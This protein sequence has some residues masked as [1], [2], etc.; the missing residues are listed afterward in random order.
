[1][2]FSPQWLALREPY[3]Q[4]A[5]NP[6]VL[7]AVRTAFAG[8]P[9]VRVADLGCGTGSTMRAV[10]P[11]L[12]AHQDW[13]LLDNDAALLEAAHDAAPAMC[14]VTTVQVDLAADLGRALADDTDLVTTSALL[15]L[16]SVHWLERLV[17]MLAISARP[18]Y[19]ALSY[20]GRVSLMPVCRN[21][22]TVI[23][24]VNRHQLTDKGFGP[25][26]GP[27]AAATAPDRLRAQGFAI[28]QG[29]SDWSFGPADRDIQLEMLA[30]W[31]GAAAAMGVGSA[32]LDDWL[33]ERRAHV[34]AACSQM[35][36]GHLDFFAAPIGR[37]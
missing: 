10:A 9:A 35:R 19:A 17:A 13:R 12:P 37:R 11:L 32:L 18:L 7:D 15:D 25:A 3:D 16:V 22:D 6:A 4:A 34:A 23:A 8:F 33:A 29:R 1:M 30:G 26:L 27:G 2:S 5:R 28:H 31:A 20:D 14:E 36:V 21:D 24:A